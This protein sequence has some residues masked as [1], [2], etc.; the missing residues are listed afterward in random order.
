MHVQSAASLRRFH[1]E[2]RQG[3]LIG[4]MPAAATAT[5]RLEKYPASASATP[6]ELL[7][8]PIRRALVEERVHSFAKILA[9]IGAQ[10]QVPALLARQG[11]TEAEHR[12]LGGFHRNR[13]MA[14]N[15]LGGFVGA[16]LQRRNVGHHL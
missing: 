14:G 10:D 7:A 12:F 3:V 13:R 5:P 15:E 16:A 2:R 1:L 9:H 11:T 4:S 8:L 6:T